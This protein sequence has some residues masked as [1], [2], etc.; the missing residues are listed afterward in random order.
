MHDNDHTCK[1][2]VKPNP[3]SKN[4]Q[5]QKLLNLL[6]VESVQGRE[7]RHQPLVRGQDSGFRRLTLQG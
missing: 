4:S 2:A 1:V 6:S 5:T 3:R 7:L